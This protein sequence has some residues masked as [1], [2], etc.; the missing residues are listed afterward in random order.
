VI[1]V[2]SEMVLATNTKSLIVFAV[3]V[4]ASMV[5]VI[6]LAPER[7]DTL[8]VETVSAFPIVVLNSMVLI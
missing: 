5:D 4:L 7:V 8:S 1:K 3:N 6:I 2:V